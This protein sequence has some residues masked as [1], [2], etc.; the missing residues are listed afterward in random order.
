MAGF[1]SRRAL[2]LIGIAGVTVLCFPALSLA[3]AA[4]PSSAQVTPAI[5]DPSASAADLERQG[6][7]LRAQKRYFD[8]IDFY[9][10]VIKKQPT[11]LLWNKEGISYLWLQQSKKAA[12]CFDR[13]I[14]LDKD[15][16]EGY[17]NRGWVEQEKHNY[18]KAI[19][20]YRKAIKLGPDHAVFH[21]N[22]GAAYFGRHNDAEAAQ[23]YKAAFTLDPGI[24]ERVSRTGIMVQATSPEDRAAFSFMVAKIYAQAGDIEHS[25]QYLR[26]AMEDGYKDI[27]KVYKESAFASLRTDKRFEELM[28]QKPAPL[29]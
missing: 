29:P 18:D 17:N 6:D 24:F 27:D 16:P 2:L 12:R 13:A 15:A 20:Y 28:A 19:K 5:P 7:E 21:Y 4:G 11:A 22:L 14:K 9:N 26:K 1:R 23:E 3:Q 8:S 25:L 10:A